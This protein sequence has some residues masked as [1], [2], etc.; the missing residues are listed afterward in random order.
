[1]EMFKIFI[2]FLGIFLTSLGIFFT[3]I[4]L[5]VLT[6]GYTFLEF[7]KFISRKIEFWF[8]FGGII[9]I[10]VS[11]EGWIKDEL[12]LRHNTKLE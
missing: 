12:L 8:I 6:M 4:Y 5:N 7:G 11:L 1:M 9:L 3:I 10:V 2:Y